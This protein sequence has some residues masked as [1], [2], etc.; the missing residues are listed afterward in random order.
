[1]RGAGYLSAALLAIAACGMPKT[2][3]VLLPNQDGSIGKLAM[4]GPLGQRVVTEPRE[5]AGFDPSKKSVEL[6]DQRIAE[7]FGKAMAAEPPK[8]L[9]FILHFRSD[10][11]E[12][13]SESRALLPRILSEVKSRI[14][15]DVDVVGHTDR[16]ATDAYNQQLGLQRANKI[17]DELIAIGIDR[18]RIIATSHGMHDPLVQTPDGVREPRNRRVEVTVR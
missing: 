12:L 11:T 14:E 18:S 4:E 5:A 15:P 7:T 13:T 16:V 9:T 17:R 10:T 3:A 8:P 2:Y 6:G 1:L